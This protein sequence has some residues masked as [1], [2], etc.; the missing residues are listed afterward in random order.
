MSVEYAIAFT[1]M[2]TIEWKGEGYTQ[3]LCLLH[4]YTTIQDIIL[5]LHVT[6][7][8]IPFSIPT[9]SHPPYHTL[10]LSLSFSLS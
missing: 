1:E 7:S 4:T 8:A 3:L 10:S 9:I 6:L 5:H 2:T